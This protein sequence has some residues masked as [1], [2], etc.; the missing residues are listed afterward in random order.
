M[1]RN[2][3]QSRLIDRYIDRDDNILEKLNCGD[4]RVC[5]L[6]IIVNDFVLEGNIVSEVRLMHFMDGVM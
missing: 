3:H 6:K 4:T 2:S 1:S 5:T